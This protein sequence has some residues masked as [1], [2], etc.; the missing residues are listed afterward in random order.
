M[1]VIEIT[2]HYGLSIDPL[3]ATVTL[4]GNFELVKEDELDTSDEPVHLTLLHEC[5]VGEV[6]GYEFIDAFTLPLTVHSGES[7][8]II[9]RRHGCIIGSLVNEIDTEET[10][11]VLLHPKGGYNVIIYQ[12]R[13]KPTS[14]ESGAIVAQP[15]Q[16]VASQS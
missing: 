15:W 5:F 1:K 16:L 7:I 13:E 8:T 11:R 10:S 6:I 3:R 9:A 14:H 4:S 2:A 12:E